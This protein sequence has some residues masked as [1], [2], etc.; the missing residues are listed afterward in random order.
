MFNSFE[1]QPNY[2]QQLSGFFRHVGPDRRPTVQTSRERTE[3]S[4]V[5][6]S[7]NLLN[8]ESLLIAVWDL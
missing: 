6:L 5:I 1:A 2:L 8:G 7:R 3:R 4:D